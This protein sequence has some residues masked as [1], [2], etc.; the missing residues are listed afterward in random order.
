M[1]IQIQM[2]E[3]GTVLSPD[4]PMDD[5]HGCVDVSVAGAATAP[6]HEHFLV[7]ARHIDMTTGRTSDAGVERRDAAKADTVILAVHL[8]PLQPMPPIPTADV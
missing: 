2:L 1:K 3:R 4:E 8:D 6:T 7:S 5:V